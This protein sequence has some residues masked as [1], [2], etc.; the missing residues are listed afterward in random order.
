MTAPLEVLARMALDAYD[1]SAAPVVADPAV[2][3]ALPDW[4]R[5]PTS[6]ASVSRDADA[7]YNSGMDANVYVDEAAGEVVVAFR[8]TEF[9]AFFDAAVALDFQ[10]IAEA[11]LDNDMLTFFGYYQDGGAT[12]EAFFDTEGSLPDYLAETFDLDEE[13]TDRIDRVVDALAVLGLSEGVGELARE[14][15]QDLRNQAESAVRTVLEV[16]AANPGK[17]ITLVGHSLGGALAAAVS[18]ALGLPAVLLDPAPYAAEGLLDHAR[19]KALAFLDGPFQALDTAALGWDVATAPEDLLA[20]LT[21]THRLDGSFVPGL[22]LTADPGDLP[23]GMSTDRVI[24]LEAFQADPFYLHTPGLVALVLDSEARASED[25]PSL[26]TLSLALPS[27]I[28]Q[29]DGGALVYPPTGDSEVFAR[30]LIVSEA[31]YALFADLLER[32]VEEVA[33]YAPEGS[34]ETQGAALERVLTDIALRALGEA[35]A[36]ERLDAPGTVAEIFGDPAGSDATDVLVG[37]FGVADDIAPGLG[38]DVIAP[39]GG[40]ADTVRGSLDA[41]DGD[42]LF[43]FDAEDR[44]IF[45]GASFGPEAVTLRPGGRSFVIDVDGDGTPEAGLGL[46]ETVAADGIAVTAVAEGTELRLTPS[47]AGASVEEARGVA[48]L[49]DAG[50]GRLADVDG[51]N[52]WIDRIEEGLEELE[53]AAIF[54]ESPEFEETVG[55]VEALEDEELVRALYDNIL[56]REGDEDGV[57]FWTEALEEEGFGPDDL[58]LAFAESAENIADLPGIDRL[59]EV[60]EGLWDFA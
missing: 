3:E 52:F 57:R 17:E 35:L 44:L 47:E 1:T 14:G 32:T 4:G 29:M 55:E 27:L 19:E 36:E 53:L 59:V 40:A 33:D 10:E 54:L 28:D 16:A 41:L 49:Y 24:D 7:S 56:G 42:L 39:G 5:Q 26:E 6:R 15:E 45:E 23:E 2:S 43:D 22:Y 8:G 37:A 25:R 46:G 18:G 60:V 30:A 20:D 12:L 11:N 51:L 9:T 38:Q 48:R 34:G 50:L 13:E 21:E 31:F 58:L